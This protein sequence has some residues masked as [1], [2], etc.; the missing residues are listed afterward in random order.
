MKKMKLD[1]ITV[2][3]YKES[4]SNGYS[5]YLYE[6]AYNNH[7]NNNHKSYN[8]SINLPHA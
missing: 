8:T 3:S 5:N 7:N 6:L 1:N 2:R 4:N